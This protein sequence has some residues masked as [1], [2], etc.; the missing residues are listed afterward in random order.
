MQTTRMNV[1]IDEVHYTEPREY[2]RNMPELEHHKV[3]EVKRLKSGRAWG[4]RKSQPTGQTKFFSGL[5]GVR[6][7]DSTTALLGLEDSKHCDD[8]FFRSS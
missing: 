4:Q 3:R 1:R 2:V 7:R 5:G 8:A 6:A